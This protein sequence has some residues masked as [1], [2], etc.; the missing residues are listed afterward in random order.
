MFNS[1]ALDYSF[2]SKDD[3]RRAIRS[4]LGYVSPWSDHSLLNRDAHA[5]K[6]RS[7]STMRRPERQNL[8]KAI[9][10]IVD[11]H[12]GTADTVKVSSKSLMKNMRRQACIF[13]HIDASNSSNARCVHAAVHAAWEL[14]MLLC[15]VCVCVCVCFPYCLYYTCHT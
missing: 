1:F 13:S 5:R 8:S 7:P 4:F 9:R 15:S 6:S 10:A 14:Y 11:D 3:I 2:I 12:C